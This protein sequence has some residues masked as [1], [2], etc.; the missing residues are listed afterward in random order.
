M[1]VAAARLA[2]VATGDAHPLVRG[3]R[4]EHPPQELAVPPLELLTL[5]QREPRSR[6]SRRQRV[7]HP[8]QLLEA[9]DARLAV[10]GGHLGL[11]SHAWKGL[12]G[13]A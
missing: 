10:G 1:P 11:D 3:G 2:D 6:D 8:L 5:A 4:L 13:E 9:G 12:G 7:P